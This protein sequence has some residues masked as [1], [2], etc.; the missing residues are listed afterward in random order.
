MYPWQAWFKPFWQPDDASSYYAPLSGPTNTNTLTDW[1]SPDININVGDPRLERAI[2][3]N[4]ATYGRQLGVVMD[5]LNALGEATKNA[6][7]P[8]LEALREMSAQIEAE[9]ERNRNTFEAKTLAALETLKSADP[10]GFKRVMGHIE[11]S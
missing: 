9:K 11:T 6:R 7:L 10:E 2:T 5:A 1:F 4:V 8:A 3:H